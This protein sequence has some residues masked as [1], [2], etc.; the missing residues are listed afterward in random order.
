MFDFTLSI[1]NFG[2]ECLVRVWSNTLT[3]GMLGFFTLTFIIYI[4]SKMVG[5]SKC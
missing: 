4:F 5:F 3:L 2:Y 1:L